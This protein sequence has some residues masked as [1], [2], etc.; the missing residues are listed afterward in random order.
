M[1]IGLTST[2]E[3]SLEELR[4]LADWTLRPRLLSVAGVSQVAVIGGDIREYQ[5]LLSPEKM[6]AYGI[7]L[8]EVLAAAREMNRNSSGGVLYEYGNE[9]IVRGMASTTDTEHKAAGLDRMTAQAEPV[10]FGDIPEVQT[11]AKAPH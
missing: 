11:G 8:D 7:T 3:T 10:T 6:D 4:T 9:Y 1:I 2:G 5:I